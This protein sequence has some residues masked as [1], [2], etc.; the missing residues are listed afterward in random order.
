MKKPHRLLGW[1]ARGLVAFED[2]TTAEYKTKQDLED[3]LFE[4]TAYVLMPDFEFNKWVRQYVEA[5]DQ[6]VYADAAQRIVGFRI[7]RGRCTRYVYNAKSAWPGM[8]R[9]G[10]GGLDRLRHFLDEWELGDQ[11]TPGALG[12]R[13]AEALIPEDERFWRPPWPAWADLHRHGVAGWVHMFARHK[14]EGVLV[15]MNSAY[16]AA[17]RINM[18][19]GRCSKIWND[20]D[21]AEEAWTFAR[22]E[23]RLSSDA[24]VVERARYTV[25]ALTTRDNADSQGGGTCEPGAVGEGWYTGVEAEAA[26]ATGAFAAF[27]C[28]G[29]W[30]WERVSSAF[31]GWTDWMDAAK[32]RYKAVA[33]AAGHEAECPCRYCQQIEA[34][35][36]K[37]ASVAVFGRFFMDAME[38]HVY[39]PGGVDAEG[40]VSVQEYGRSQVE[41]QFV[42]VPGRQTDPTKLPHLACH[43]WSVTRVELARTMDL[44]RDAGWEVFMC[45]IDGVYAKQIGRAHV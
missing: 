25:L 18:P 15:D 1:A 40:E 8:E 38:T 37:R 17:A 7:K 33:E 34:G 9:L 24:G 29:G 32:A 26:R 14:G 43:V 3:L 44:A 10:A 31:A 19:A 28:R 12:L 41:V 21:A 30:G 20:G 16:P 23:W 36:V 6:C 4:K 42:R 27:E 5:G 35:W 22:Y 39:A 13:A 11:S 45:A 2:D